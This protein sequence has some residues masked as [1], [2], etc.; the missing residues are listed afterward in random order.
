MG[1]KRLLR[2][3]ELVL[4]FWGLRLDE[5]DGRIGNVTPTENCEA[6]HQNLN[7]RRHKRIT[8][9]L[10]WLGEFDMQAY[11]APLVRALANL[12]FEPPYALWNLRDSLH[13]NFVLVV[14]HD[15]EREA[16]AE[17]VRLL[18]AKAQQDKPASDP[19][20][21]CVHS[22]ESNC[23]RKVKTYVVVR[24]HFATGPMDFHTSALK[25]KA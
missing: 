9:V 10:K 18:R 7:I 24:L 13:N 23:Q 1:K 3:Y 11:Q 6:R 4:D 25:A 15:A 2:S 8:R 16:L 17:E 12:V 21:A 14:R 22:R 5:A 20:G 19:K